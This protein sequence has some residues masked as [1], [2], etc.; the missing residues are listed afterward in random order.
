MRGPYVSSMRRFNHHHAKTRV[1]VENTFVR[2]KG[3]W[4]V[5][6]MIC[7]HLQLA[8]FIQDVA[9]AQHKFWSR[10]IGRMKRAWRM[11]RTAARE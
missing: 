8:S 11:R 5:L 6:R 2:P 10:A 9:A 4:N 7:T 3:R 1:V